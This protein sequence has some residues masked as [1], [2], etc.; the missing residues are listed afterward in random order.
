MKKQLVTKTTIKINKVFYPAGT[1]LSEELLAGVGGSL[2]Q[3]MQDK[4]IVEESVAPVAPPAPV[5]PV[6]P[7]KA[8]DKKVEDKKEKD[9][10]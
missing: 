10:K 9:K 4:A 8:E 6:A 3:L 2:S 1:V 7:Q 5:A